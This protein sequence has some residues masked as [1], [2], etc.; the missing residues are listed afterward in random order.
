MEHGNVTLAHF[1]L[2]LLMTIFPSDFAITHLYN[3]FKLEQLP[4]T[5]FEL[6]S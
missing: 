2:P 4:H 3:N 6:K 1:H 5:Y